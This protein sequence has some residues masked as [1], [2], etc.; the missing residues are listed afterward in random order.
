MVEILSRLCLAFECA[1]R[2]DK[3]WKV[4][5]LIWA[6]LRGAT[7]LIFPSRN[8]KDC[9]KDLSDHDASPI[10]RTTAVVHKERSVSA[11][12]KV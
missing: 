2:L 6:I 1:G 10:E 11:L 9:E 7:L 4:S 5:T 8:D 3:A 12:T